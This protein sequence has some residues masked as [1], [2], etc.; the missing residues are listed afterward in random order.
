MKAMPRYTTHQPGNIITEEEQA[1][2]V[3]KLKIVGLA[4]FALLLFAVGYVAVMPSQS[5]G[6]SQHSEVQLPPQ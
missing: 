4:A 2:A 3:R 6:R 5:I 1:Q